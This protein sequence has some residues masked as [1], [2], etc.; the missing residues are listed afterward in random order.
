MELNELNAWVILQSGLTHQNK[1]S[2][3][4]QAYVHTGT[5]KDTFFNMYGR[6]YRRRKFRMF[7]FYFMYRT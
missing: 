4:V 6:K 7:T 2:Q 1:G 5:G 3:A